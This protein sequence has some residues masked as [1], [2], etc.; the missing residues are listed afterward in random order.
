MTTAAAALAAGMS[1]DGLRHAVRSG[2]WL[3]LAQGVYL[4]NPGPPLRDDWINAGVALAGPTAALTG[5]D[6]VRTFGLGA[7][8]PPSPHALLLT[9]TGANRRLPGVHVRPTSR[10][11]T[12][13]LLPGQHPT[14]PYVPVVSA[15][16][17]VADTALLHTRLAPVRAMVTSAVQ[18]G[19]CRPDE[20]VAE[21]ATT[22][23]G[24]S[25]LLRRAV[26]DALAGAGS[27][28]EAEAA[29]WLRA[30]GAPAF[31]LNAPI[32]SKGRVI[33]IADVL[34]R[35]LRA[36]LEIDSREFHFSEMEWKATMTRHNALTALG[37][38]VAHYP[39]SRIR[40]APA[41][42]GREVVAW[43]ARRAMELGV[44]LKP[45]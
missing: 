1:Y 13:R 22:P 23:R 4:T 18:R 42:W 25:A 8:T 15:A 41:S 14:L 21:L 2:R 12:T 33:A 6:A 3:R 17:A 32:R 11:Y 20:L 39:P 10:T 35:P 44:E 36:V 31:E 28:A 34:W 45:A 30:A 7:R 38:A 40:S 43:L 27:I 5:W 37:Y 29:D 16:R 9:C 24:R 26:E 19:A